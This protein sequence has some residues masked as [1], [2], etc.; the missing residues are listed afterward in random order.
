M[1]E[2]FNGLF[3]S[4]KT[5]ATV[6]ALIFAGALVYSGKVPADKFT[7]LLGAL[8]AILVGAIA[9]E[10]GKAKGAIGSAMIVKAKSVEVP[11]DDEV[12]P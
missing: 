1:L 12:V 7:E 5:L 4:R 9:Y 6:L 10:D 2:S 8:T 11:P 3:A